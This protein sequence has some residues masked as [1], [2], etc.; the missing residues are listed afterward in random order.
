MSRKPGWFHPKIAE[1]TQDIFMCYDKPRFHV[2]YLAEI[3][4]FYTKNFI[5]YFFNNWV[6]EQLDR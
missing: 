4:G 2:N 3:K 1:D 5:L 6:A